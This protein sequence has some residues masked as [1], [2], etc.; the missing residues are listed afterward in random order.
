MNKEKILALAGIVALLLGAASPVLA[1]PTQRVPSIQIHW[2]VGYSDIAEAFGAAVR[3]GIFFALLVAGLFMIFGGFKYVTAGD[4][5]KN[6][7]AARTMMTNAVIGVIVVASVFLL[8]KIMVMIIP[9][10]DSIINL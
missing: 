6:A 8:L 1:A 5:P 9:G 7:Q 3:W 4:D 2:Y 10:L